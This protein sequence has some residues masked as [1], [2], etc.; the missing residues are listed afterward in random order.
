MNNVVFF[1]MAAGTT[2]VIALA[3]LHFFLC[4]VGEDLFCP[5][6]DMVERRFISD[7]TRYVLYC[8]RPIT[9]PAALLGL[10][11]SPAPLS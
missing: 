9:S 11:L 4:W 7:D 6:L 5:Q 2:A 1:A 10:F 3:R 8:A